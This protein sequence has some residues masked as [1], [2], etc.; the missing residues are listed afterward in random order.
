MRIDLP[1]ETIRNLFEPYIDK[2]FAQNDARWN[3][4]VTTLSQSLK[5]NRIRRQLLGWLMK[6]Y[7]RTQ[8]GIEWN[9]TRQWSSVSLEK[10]FSNTGSN[11]VPCEWRGQGMLA[12]GFGTKKLHQALLFRVLEQCAPQSVLEVGFGNGINLFLMACRFPEISFSGVELTE[13]GVMAAK[14]VVKESTL[15]EFISVVS[16][17][18]LKDFSAHTKVDLRKAS[19]ADLPFKDNSFDLVFTSL[20]LEQMEEVRTR[21]LKEIQRVSKKYVAMLEPFRD[22]NNDGLRRDYIIANDYFAAWIDD[23]PRYGLRPVFTTADI[24][25]KLRMRVG[26]VV[27]EVIKN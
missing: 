13:G 27:A 25:N 1:D 12:Y 16:P 20:A 24:P 23:L 18:P 15:P 11:P 17:E 9:Y 5:K 14:A 7:R 19:A 8:A 22:W 10:Q 26:L 21:A 3:E 2:K 4:I 6:R